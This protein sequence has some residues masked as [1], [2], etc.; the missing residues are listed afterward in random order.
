MLRHSSPGTK[1]GSGDLGKGKGRLTAGEVVAVAVAP[2][3]GEPLA[4]FCLG[5]PEPTN[6]LRGTIALVWRGEGEKG[7]GISWG[8][9]RQMCGFGK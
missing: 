3:V 9:G 4:G 5:V 2:A 1:K 6:K 8:G 7:G